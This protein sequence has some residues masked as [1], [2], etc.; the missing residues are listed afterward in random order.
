MAFPSKYAPMRAFGRSTVG[1]SPPLC[2][3]RPM[4]GCAASRVR[5]DVSPLLSSGP[6]GDSR[7]AELEL[8]TFMIFCGNGLTSKPSEK[9]TRCTVVSSCALPF[10][11]QESAIGSYTR[12]NLLFESWKPV[13]CPAFLFLDE[14]FCLKLTRTVCRRIP[15]SGENKHTKGRPKVN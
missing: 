6:S 3:D 8:A 9:Y 1:V 11:K 12:K 14:T 2:F 15:F 5:M 13:F 10:W 7:W 4:W